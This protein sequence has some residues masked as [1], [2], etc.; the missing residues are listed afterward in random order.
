MLTLRQIEVIR[1]IMI[2][3]TVNGAAELL[4]V[5]SPGVSRVMK[6]AEKVLGMRLFQRRHAADK[7]RQS[8]RAGAGSFAAQVTPTVV[9]VFAGFVIGYAAL[10]DVLGFLPASLLFLFVA[11]HFLHRRHVAFSFAVALGALIAI[12]VVFRL[13]FSV[14]LPEGIVPER[15][16]MAWIERLFSPTEVTP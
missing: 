1:A 5:S 6:H 8:G 10:L 15:E 2:S 14:V 3:G 7:A 13:V 16:I 9:V 4:H 11:I 12:Y